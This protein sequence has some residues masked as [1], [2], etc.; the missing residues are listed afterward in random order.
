[1]LP[2]LALTLLVNLV[3]LK[4]DLPS[5]QP[6]VTST[7]F[8]LIYQPQGMPELHTFSVFCHLLPPPDIF[9]LTVPSR[10]FFLVV[11]DPVLE[12]AQHIHDY[13]SASSTDCP[14]GDVSGLLGG[15]YIGPEPYV[16]DIQ[17]RPGE[18]VS[19]NT[20]PI[21]ATANTQLRRMNDRDITTTIVHPPVYTIRVFY[22]S[23]PSPIPLVC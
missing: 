2:K 3:L 15:E 22:R 14:R 11:A 23:S 10:R 8:N 7:Y 6:R 19:I 20:C 4:P 17:R 21:V 18:R 12:F 9:H 5:T 16:C 13:S 1:M